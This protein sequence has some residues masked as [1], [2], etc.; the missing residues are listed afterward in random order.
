MPS[1]IIKPNSATSAGVIT[2]AFKRRPRQLGQKVSEAVNFEP[3]PLVGRK[4]RPV[5]DTGIVGA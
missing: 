4:L 5:R 3:F 2:G 1:L